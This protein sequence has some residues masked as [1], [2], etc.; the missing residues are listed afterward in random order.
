MAGAATTILKAYFKG[1]YVIPSPVQ[2]SDDGLSLATYTG[3]ALT[4]EGELN[5]LATNIS[6]GRDAAGVHFRSD[7]DPGLALGEAMAISVLRDLVN[8]YHENFAGFTFNKF[9]GTSITI[10]KR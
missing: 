4:I 2:A 1:S 7:G 6:I 8:G 3:P 5:K 10:S 9:D